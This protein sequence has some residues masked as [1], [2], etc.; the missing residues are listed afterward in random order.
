MD[1]LLI[2][3]AAFGASGLTLYSGFGLGTLLMP[4]FAVFFPLELA[5]SLTAF[6]HL[7]NNLF[8][9]WL[10]GKHTDFKIVLSFG[11]PA[12]LSAFAGAWCLALFAD[13]KPL[14]S[15]V[16]FDIIAEV[17][18]LKLL[19]AALMIFFVLA[20]SLPVFKNLAFEQK[21][22]PLGGMLSGFF[23]GLSGNQGAF[24]SA[25]LVQCG[26]GRERFIG[27][28]VVIACLVDFV[29]LAVYSSRF[30]PLL[31]DR[32]NWPYAIVGTAAAFAGAI[33]GNLWIKKVTIQTIQVLVSTLL[34]MIALG[35]ATGVV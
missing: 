23:G 20:E 8:K 28:G 1:Y 25:F 22:L 2:G 15:Y 11:V 34:F 6:V 35:L 3:A 10:F 29:R 17:T 5:V 30:M 31:A 24:R 14:F 26:L 32:K 19:I 12:V 27:T 33:L 9:L 13:S 7:A 18:I 16:L 4:V 21:H